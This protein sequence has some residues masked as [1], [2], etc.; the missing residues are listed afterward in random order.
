LVLYLKNTVFLRKYIDELTIDHIS[1]IN[2]RINLLT[3]PTRYLLLEIPWFCYAFLAMWMRKK[4]LVT[5]PAIVT[6]A[7]LMN[8]E[9]LF[10]RNEET[11]TMSEFK[12]E[13]PMGTLLKVWEDSWKHLAVHF[14]FLRTRRGYEKNLRDWCQQ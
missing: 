14:N 1:S 6:V 8:N 12:K 10:T 4:L 11:P 5:F 7:C 2:S 9:Y 13:T 3:L